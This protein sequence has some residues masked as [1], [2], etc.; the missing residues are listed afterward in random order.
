MFNFFRQPREREMEIDFSLEFGFQLP[1]SLVVDI[2]SETAQLVEEGTEERSA[3]K[4]E[5]SVKLAEDIGR[6]HLARCDTTKGH[7]GSNIFGHGVVVDACG[8][9][10]RSR[11]RFQD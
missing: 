5:L 4:G 3:P 8:E 1:D 10:Q 9:F 7:K 11:L 2:S 6:C